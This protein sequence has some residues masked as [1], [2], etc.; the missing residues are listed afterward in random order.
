M[1]IKWVLNILVIALIG[2]T[3]LLAKKPNI[4]CILVDD[5]GYS[6]LSSFGGTDIKTPAIDKLMNSGMR[7][8]QFYANCN[9][10]TPY[11]G[12]SLDRS[13]TPTLSVRPE[14]SAKIQKVTGATSTRQVQRYLNL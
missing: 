10:C 11:P 14:S 9:V 6:D 1:I 13:L 8:N 2:A 5:L 4:I 3:T 12:I 7:M